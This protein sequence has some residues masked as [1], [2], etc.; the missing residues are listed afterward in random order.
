MLTLP[1]VQSLTQILRLALELTSAISYIHAVGWVHESIRPQNILICYSKDDISKDS[2]MISRQPGVLNLCG[3]GSSR[4]MAPQVRSHG[5]DDGDWTTELYCHPERQRKTLVREEE[6]RSSRLSGLSGSTTA[7]NGQLELVRF[8]PQHD[9]YSL[10]VVLLEL[11]LRKDLE[12]LG[13]EPSNNN[14]HVDKR[15]TS[16]GS[17]EPSLK[18]AEPEDRKQMLKDTS[19]TLLARRVG[20]PWKNI[21]VKCLEGESS[22]MTA[23]KIWAQIEELRI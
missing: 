9:I 3:F 18:F 14:D 21:V 19:A 15:G 8:E 11:G 6:R 17:S 1:S 12:T 2:N 10:G 13:L 5:P 23:E 4:R 20:D 22:Q 16:H 7:S